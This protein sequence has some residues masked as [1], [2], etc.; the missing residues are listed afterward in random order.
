M[1]K[2]LRYR[3]PAICQHLASQYVAGVMTPRVRRRT[4][5]LRQ[6]NPELDR[7]IAQWSDRFSELHERLPPATLS[8][9]TEAQLW[10]GI[11]SQLSA[12]QPR[13]KRHQPKQ[14][15]PQ[16]KWWRKWWTSLVLWRSF[17]G[18][19][20][21]ASVLLALIVTLANP[22]PPIP[23][24]PTGPSYLATMAAEGDP[25]QGVQFVISAY[26]KQEGKPSRLHLQWLKQDPK[27]PQPQAQTHPPLHLWA[28]QRESGELIYIGLK[29]SEGQSWDLTKPMWT[30]I[31]NSQRL[32]ITADA[33]RPSKENLLFSGL[34]LQLGA[35]QS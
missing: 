35:W 17:S 32:L 20:A 29:P 12:P 13:T 28:E 33:Q 14:Y 23:L 22:T 21:L 4:Q 11:Q 15:Q 18:V 30:A 24:A 8:P 9:S 1:S 27:Q 16:R 25:E 6:Q 26:A 10:Q 7:A 34:C 5:T 31:A 2:R 3:Q 19:G